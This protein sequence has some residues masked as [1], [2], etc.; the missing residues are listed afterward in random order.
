MTLVVGKITAKGTKENVL[1]MFENLEEYYDKDLLSQK[2][3]EDDYTIVFDYSERMDSFFC[4][5]G[6]MYVS[7]EYDCEISAEMTI[8]DGDPSGIITLHYN[9]G[10]IIR[11]LKDNGIDPEEFDF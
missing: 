2:G 1:D 6:F 8:D 5:D 11:G 4:C 9:R 3:T 10:D 7:E